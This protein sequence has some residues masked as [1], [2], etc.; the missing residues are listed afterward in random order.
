MKK[1]KINLESLATDAAILVAVGHVVE[2]SDDLESVTS[3]GDHVVQAI[4]DQ[5]NLLVEIGVARQRVDGD[6]AERGEGA[7]KAGA[8]TEQP[9]R[10]EV[11]R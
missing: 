10:R 8:L 1:K 3:G 5:R 6:R 9:F 11:V 4:G 2:L 7:L